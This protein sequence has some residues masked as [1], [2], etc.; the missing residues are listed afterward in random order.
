MRMVGL[1]AIVVLKTEVSMN[2]GGAISRF[3][4]SFAS[5]YRPSA[6]LRMS[7]TKVSGT[8]ACRDRATRVASRPIAAFISLDTGHHAK[9]R[10]YRNAGP[11]NRRGNGRS[12]ATARLRRLRQVAGYIVSQRESFVRTH[13]AST[14]GSVF[15]R[16]G[17]LRG[18]RIAR[19]K[20]GLT[21]TSDIFE[22]TW[23]VA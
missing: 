12:P 13:R 11:D 15:A 16:W 20:S 23:N 7:Q 14:S 18:I 5:R 17:H 4:E 19:A 21:P 8:P 9:V 3:R 10:T 2:V 22:C 1:L 6:V